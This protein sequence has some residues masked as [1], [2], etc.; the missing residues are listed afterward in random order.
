[1]RPGRAARRAGPR[2]P[3]GRRS[4]ARSAAPHASAAAVAVPGRP[5]RRRRRLGSRSTSAPVT[6]SAPG[7]AGGRGER[8]GDR[9]HA[10]DRHP[11]LAGAVADQVVEE[12]AVLD[13]A[14]GRAC[15]RRCRS[16]ASVA[17]TPRTVSSAK[18]VSMASPSGRSTRSRQSAG[19]TCAADLA[20]R[21][22]SGSVS[23][24]ATRRG[25]LAD[26]AVERAA[27]P[28]TRRRSRSAPRNDCAR[29][30]RPRAARRAARRATPSRTYRR[31]G[32][33]RPR[34]AAAGRGRGRR[35]SAR[36]AA[37]PGRSSATAGRGQPGNACA[38]DR[39]AA[40]VVEPLEDQH[41]QPGP[42]E[43]GRGGQPVVAAADDH[44]VVPGVAHVT[45]VEDGRPVAAR[46]S[47]GVDRDQGGDGDL[48][49]AASSGLTE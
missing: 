7:A 46:P 34:R 6:S 13:A 20:A 14:T 10:A 35:R 17:T 29:G 11:P 3:T 36:A 40:G 4:P 22:G 45:T 12:A 38:D 16:G 43:V 15:A 49:S 25:E 2:A 39:R 5:R 31:V 1:M 33:R 30:A 48:A 32:R 18:R 27:R 37:R 44:D 24:G 8:V 28:R 21:R 19:S 47:R 41:R 26:L 42:G 9:A 23:V